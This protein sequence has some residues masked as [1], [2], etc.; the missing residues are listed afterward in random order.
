MPVGR[1]T[2]VGGAMGLTRLI[3]SFLFDI[4]LWGPLSVCRR[5]ADSERG[6]AACSVAARKSRCS[7]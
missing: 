4:K 5:A 7:T 2:G 3:M 1:V 6:G